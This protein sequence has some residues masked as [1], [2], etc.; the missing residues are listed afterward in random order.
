[1]LLNFSIEKVN[2]DKGQSGNQP[3]YSQGFEGGI[4]MKEGPGQVSDRELGTLGSWEPLEVLGEEM[5][6]KW[7]RLT[8]W[9]SPTRGQI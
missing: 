6:D 5:M 8:G 1:M 3:G 9:S 2:E 7:V 4:S